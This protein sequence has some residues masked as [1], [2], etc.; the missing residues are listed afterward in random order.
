MFGLMT[1]RAHEWQVTYQREASRTLVEA[2]RGALAQAESD[3]EGWR[4]LATKLAG[5]V[6]E[7]RKRETPE[8]V[9]PEAA[10][11]ARIDAGDHEW[12]PSAIRERAKRSEVS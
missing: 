6:V 5:D 1:V 4:F 9:S 3:A 7:L 8:P 10:G 2:L 11:T 12:T